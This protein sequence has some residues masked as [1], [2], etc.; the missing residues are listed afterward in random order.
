MQPSP[1]VPDQYGGPALGIGARIY[2]KR[3]LLCKL[4]P[5]TGT[6]AAG[7]ATVRATGADVP[8][9]VNAYAI[10]LLQNIDGQGQADY[11]RLIKVTTPT[12]VTAAGTSVPIF[13]ALGG[14]HQNGVIAGTKLRWSPALP[15]IELDSVVATGLSGAADLTVPGALKRIVLFD[16]LGIGNVALKTS[17]PLSPEYWRAKVGDFPAGILI[18]L[19]SQK[20]ERVGRGM[21]L[22][23]FM[24]RL[25][26]ADSRSDE[27]QERYNDGDATLDWAEGLLED[28]G[29][30]DN[31][32]FSRGPIQCG[33]AKLL[34]AEDGA[35]L[36][37]LDFDSWWT[38][39]RIEP[40]IFA[41][42]TETEVTTKTVPDD[43]YPDPDDAITTV[44]PINSSHT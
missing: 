1:P 43:E 31:E 11:S 26:V 42:W 24:W 38:I 29:E 33:G 18:L 30:V 34:V 21:R 20:G 40:G 2:I 6:R 35:F 15:G 32:C 41:A 17:N 10:P 36:H 37:A 19:G 9:P 16:R 14:V 4:Q 22:H 3:S 23:R 28:C 12:T 27:T 44:G 39:Q 5:L 8:L 13:S 7:I 25:M